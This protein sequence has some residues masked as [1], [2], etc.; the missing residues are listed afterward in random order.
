MI[1]AIRRLVRLSGPAGEKMVNK[2][3]V[4]MHII[5]YLLIIIVDII[6]S[7]LALGKNNLR[8][9]EISQICNLAVYSLCNLLFGVIVYQLA[10]K[11]LAINAFS[12]SSGS[13]LIAATETTV[14][15]NLT[16]KSIKNS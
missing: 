10:N 14:K 8:E 12:E 6:T 7:L 11:I 1:C 9:F 16:R 5:A 15:L 13:S 3:I 4:T 2:L